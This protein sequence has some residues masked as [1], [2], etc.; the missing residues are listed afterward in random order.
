[1]NNAAPLPVDSKPL[2]PDNM[3]ALLENARS[4]AREMKP[5]V[6]QHPKTGKWH[7]IDPVMRWPLGEA[8]DTREDAILVWREQMAVTMAATAAARS[9]VKRGNLFES[10]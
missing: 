4:I 1:M 6:A 7:A 8:S 5:I 9:E 3:N 10:L 2:T